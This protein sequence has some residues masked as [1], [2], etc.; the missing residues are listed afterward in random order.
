M[1][2]GLA[3]KVAVV[4]GAGG[5]IGAATARSLAAE[6]AAVVIGDVDMAALERTADSIR[7]AGG[8]VLAVHLDVSSEVSWADAVAKGIAAF[9]G[10]DVLVNNAGINSVADA[11][12][13]E[14][15]RGIAGH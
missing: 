13:R 7:S 6:G 10:L 4:T 12:G 15:Q 11:V 14:A 2:T 5:A 1:D 8:R 3:G 9:G